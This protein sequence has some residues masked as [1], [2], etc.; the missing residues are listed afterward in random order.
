MHILGVDPGASG[1]FALITGSRT[2]AACWPMPETERDIFELIANSGAQHI[3]IEA[4]HSM[5][6]QGVASS[7][8]FGRNYGFLRA[9]IIASGVPFENVSPQRWQKA[10]NCLT[11]GDKNVSKSKAQQLYP[12][13]KIT[14]AVADALLIATYCS[15]FSLYL[16]QRKIPPT[17]KTRTVLVFEGEEHELKPV[18]R[19]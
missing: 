1:G 17:P 13:V 8:K 7:F 16:P 6:K 4:V 9:C 14:H 18:R 11:G 3:C 12:H 10:L 19:Q 2:G 15:R 5:P